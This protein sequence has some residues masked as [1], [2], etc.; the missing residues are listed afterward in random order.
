MKEKLALF[1]L[2]GTLYDTRMVNYLAYNKALGNFGYSIDYDYFAEKCNGRHYKVF[3]PSIVKNEE[4]MEKVHNL[5]KEYYNDFLGKARENTEL[6]SLL[7]AIR[8]E[9]YLAVVTTASRKNCEEILNFNNRLD[10][11]DL[12]ISQEEVTNK[13]PNPECYIKAMEHFGIE[14]KDT[15]IFE[16]SDV[17]VKAAEATGATVFVVKGFA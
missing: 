3:L 10:N 9:Y 5:K 1:D 15:I 6:F 4:E 16:D 2:D 11:F 14:S 13:K 17:G 7:N 8:D 12:I